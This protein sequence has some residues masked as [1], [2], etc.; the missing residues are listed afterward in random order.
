[1]RDLN[2]VQLIG[3]LGAVPEVRFTPSGL[4]VANFSLATNNVYRNG[5]GDQV[6]E[7][8]WHRIVLWGKTAEIAKQYL[9]KGSRLYLE[10]RIQYR[11]WEDKETGVARLASEI[12]GSQ[13][14]FLSSASAPGVVAVDEAELE[15]AF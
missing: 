11:K 3:R 10:G 9:N 4:A 13:L 1:M 14:I 7:V 15:P 6:D 8:A 2:K 12:V 5:A